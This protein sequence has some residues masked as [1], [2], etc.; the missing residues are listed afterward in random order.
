ML[1]QRGRAE[2]WARPYWAAFWLL[3]QSLADLLGTLLYTKDLFSAFMMQHN[4]T[5]QQRHV[6][7]SQR[8]YTVRIIRNWA[9][10]S[11]PTMLNNN[12]SISSYSQLFMLDTQT[13]HAL[14][15]QTH[16]HKCS[17]ILFPLLLRHTTN[18]S[19]GARRRRNLNQKER[20]RKREEEKVV[21]W[22]LMCH[23]WGKMN[24][25][26]DDIAL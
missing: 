14:L 13:H 4:A 15:T 10:L 6:W 8:L 2:M 17:N 24:D 20:H 25:Q 11:A 7:E 21:R 26:D 16:T 18:S 9:V 3:R 12:I 1:Q 19:N 23:R 5:H 22:L